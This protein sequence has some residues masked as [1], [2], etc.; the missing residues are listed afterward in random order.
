MKKLISLIFICSTF[1]SYSQNYVDAVA[2]SET[3]I[4]GNARYT[5]MAG[6]FGA[7]GGNLTGLLSNPAGLGVY[8]ENT[9]EFSLNYRN[10]LNKTDYLNASNFRS[11]TDNFIFN[12]IGFS[13]A[14][15]TGKNDLNIKYLNFA[16]SMNKTDIHN[17]SNIFNTTNTNNSY[18]DDLLSRSLDNINDDYVFIASETGLIFYDTIDNQYYSDFRQPDAEGNIQ[19][20]YGQEQ[21]FNIT[22]KGRKNTY[23]FSFG[24]NINDRVYFGFGMNLINIKYR[25]RVDI[26]ENDP[27][28]DIAYFDSFTSS[29]ITEIS[30]NGF[31][32]SIGI[33]GKPIEFLRVGLAY[34]T[35]EVY[36]FT[37][38]HKIAFDTYL[39][40]PE[41]PGD[42]YSESYETD[43]SF[44]SPSKFVGSVGFVYKNYASLNVDYEYKDFSTA[45]FSASD[46]DFLTENSAIT[47][48]LTSAHSLKI[49]G[50]LWAGAFGF[51]AGFAN[52][53]S[54]YANNLLY[55]TNKN[56]FSIGLGIREDNFFMDFAFIQSRLSYDEYLYSDIAYKP[57]NASS[58]NV[59]NQLVTTIG[60]KL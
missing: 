4:T 22:K 13:S 25:C 26:S 20:N 5:A 59:V 50:E 2:M 52:E 31:G 60:F 32:A 16:I 6:S 24:A 57:I 38:L 49:G 19:T 7:L 47:S 18:T 40:D 11:K 44:Y 27:Y 33:I 37:H 28:D 9:C 39:S 54:P 30:G 56:S 34:H 21:K 58:N 15:K 29:D 8:R 42:Y 23:N 45:Y 1:I 46:Y 14:Y 17:S 41:H 55:T 48:K 12:N 53:T 3:D 43:N 10:S 35:P 36:S 51:R